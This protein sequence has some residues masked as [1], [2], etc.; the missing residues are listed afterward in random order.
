VN[1]GQAF[2][3]DDKYRL[4][5]GT[6]YL[7]GIQALVRLPIEQMRRDRLAGLRTAAFISGYEGSPLGG[8]DLA[9]QRAGGLLAEHNIRFAPGVNE[10]LAATAVM[11]SQTYQMLPDPQVDGVVGIW[12]GKGPGVDRSGDVLRHANLAGTGRH[13][14]ALALAGDD[15]VSKSSTIP[16][17]SEFS[18]YN[19]GM[20]TLTPGSPQEILDYGLLGIALSRYCGAWTGLKLATDVCDG[21]GTVEVSP[22]RCRSVEPEYLIDGEP[23]RKVMNGLLLVPTSLELEKELLY[24][25]HEA[26]R[27]F[28][29]AND[30]N[31]IVARHAHDRFGIVAAG[32]AYYDLRSALRNLG[33]DESE[34][35]QAGVR[36]LK[37]GMVFPLEPRIIEEFS[38]GLDEVL[39]IEEKRS[40]IELQLRDLLYNRDPRPAIYGKSDRNGEPLLPSHGELDAEII[41]KALAPQLGVVPDRGRYLGRIAETE[42]LFT[43]SKGAPP[44]P[45]TYCSGC[46]HNRST[47]LLEGQ[48]AGGGIGCHGMA[49]M[50]GEAHRGI[51]YLGHMGGEGAAWIGMSPFTRRE[52]LFQNIGDGTYFHSGRQAVH[53]AVA[54]GVNIT[55][56][57][58]FNN[59]VAMTGGQDV[60]GGLTIPAL[61]RELESAGV[62][63][64]VL[65]SDDP[66]KYRHG[67]GLAAPVKLRPREDLE[68][69]L[70]DLEKAPGATALIYD[71]MCAAEKRR[72]RNRGLLPQAVRRVVIHERVCE[73]CGDCVAKSNCVSL[74]PVETEFGPKTRIHQSSCNAD[75]SCVLGDC[76]SFVSVMVE[77]GTGLKRKP[78]PELPA[79]EIPEPARK[80]PLQGP[81]HILM[82]GIGGTGVVTV[83]ALLATAALLEG[84]H[85]TTLDQTGLAQKGGAV[86]SHLTLSAA[87]VETSNRISCGAADLL[88]GFDVMGAAGRGNLQRLHPEKTVAVVNSHEI[89][90]AETVRKGLTVVSAGGWFLDTI[91]RF[92]R[93]AENIFVDASKIAEELFGGHLY[94]NVFLLGVAFQAGRIP[95][96]CASIEQAVRLNGVAVARNLEAFAWGRK[97]IDDPGAVL[98][99]AGE[100]KT[101]PKHSFEELLQHR[102]R[103]LTRYQ[104]AAY[105]QQYRAFV[106]EVHG[107]EQ[108]AM[109]GST[110][111]AAAVARNLYK[112]MAYKDEYEVARLLIDPEFEKQVQA[113][114][115]T[116]RKLVYHL[117][118]PL[119][120]ALGLKRK[121]SLGPWFR[122]ILKVLAAGKRLRGTAFDPFG[123]A[124]VRQEERRL[125]EWYRDTMRSQLPGLA[126]RLPLAV[127]IAGLPDQIRG[128]E[129]IKLDSARRVRQAAADLLVESRRETAA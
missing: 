19:V 40:F 38:A 95:L 85:A 24:R 32:K 118:P 67:A 103:E 35:E 100:G 21:G 106:E 129:H 92:T 73:G 45:P 29:L 99:L 39:V 127:E 102:C 49:A 13:C 108:H 7:T 1:E 15:H 11:G 126:R 68:Q 122:P 41:A 105:A 81:Y 60:A 57:I 96:R 110:R 88:L 17:Q 112:L 2:S 53:A 104:D 3:L 28:A 86:V 58:L 4:E 77:E 51:A 90:T 20:P 74:H 8:Y 80:V 61:T 25:R 62:K 9:L 54:S 66:H 14:G 16:H 48:I 26:A 113:T 76:P 93:A 117:H 55:Y 43:E 33:L 65:L 84:K 91:T 5:R 56:K 42:Q 63:R 31:H 109:P 22:E 111:F 107:A 115:E 101:P 82:P 47:F 37:L 83:N 50:L 69:A 72:R 70:A 27:R 75:Y 12:Y 59:V 64:I 124:A 44:R 46:P 97:Y 71:Q 6:V 78:L 121:L 125:I 34:L 128:Y 123:R 18:F 94:T 116:P 119:L 52:H 89:P 98:A 114:F 36:I 79:V 10:D 120:R 30:L 23:Y 87:P